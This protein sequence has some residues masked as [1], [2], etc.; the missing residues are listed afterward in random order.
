M[1]LPVINPPSGPMRSAPTV[2]TSSGMPARLA[3]ELDHTPIPFAAWPGEFVLGERGH[4]DPRA[5]RVDPRASLAPANRL[6]HHAQ[7]VPA[8]RELVCVKGIGH[9]VGPQERKP[10]QLLNGCGGQRPVLLDGERGQAAAWLAA[11]QFGI[12]CLWWIPATGDAPW[13]STTKPEPSLQRECRIPR[14]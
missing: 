7:R 11:T 10:E 13:S 6:G 2:P 9:L 8:F 1:S 3:A 4:N 14:M 5:D 12:R